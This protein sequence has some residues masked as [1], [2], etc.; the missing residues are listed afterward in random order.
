MK[1]FN[2]V[3]KMIIDE[4]YIDKDIL[5]LVNSE[6]RLQILTELNNEPQTVREIVD[7]T[8]MAYSSVSNNLSK[9][10]RKNHVIKEDRIYTINPMTKI[11]FDQIMEFKK[12]IDVVQNF[13]SFWYKH[14]INYINID[15]IED[16]TK[17]YKSK[18]IETNPIDIYKTHNNIKIQLENSANVKGI[19][20]YIHPE[21]PKLIEGILKN[22]GSI[23]LIMEKNIYKGLSSQIDEKVKRRSRKNGRLKIH[24]LKE[25]LEIYL[26][27]CDNKMN[28]GL[29][30]NDGS[31]DQNR[32]LTSNTEESINWANSLFETI[33]E[34]VI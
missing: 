5:F 4:N 19:L 11:Y 22:N 18:L 34:K 8:N 6:I 20:P 7:R 26:L 28:L 23:E 30:K 29:F 3:M 21:Y 25:N 24:A 31:Y 12:S 2:A 14:D 27:I 9:L 17:L 15:L 33:K 13:N 32:I 1:K 16:I 10:E